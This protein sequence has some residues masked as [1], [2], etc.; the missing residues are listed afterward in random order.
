MISALVQ[1][2]IY[3]CEPER[4]L[5]MTAANII[6]VIRI[7]LVPIFMFFLVSELWCAAI[8]I[9]LIAAATDWVDGF[10]ARKYNQVTTFGKFIDPLADKLLVTA[11][12]IGLVSLQMLSPWFALIIISREFIVTSLR[13][14]AISKGTVIAAAFSGKL[15]TTMQIIAIVAAI[16]DRVY[17]LSIGSFLFSGI[18][19]IAAVAITIYSGA[20]YIVV[21]REKLYEN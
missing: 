1:V 13:I 21:N 18:L 7:F 20:E 10:V 6:T 8:I 3:L 14:V 17:A 11:A 15:K 5:V 9:F 19:M 2:L 12:L 16:G 4:L